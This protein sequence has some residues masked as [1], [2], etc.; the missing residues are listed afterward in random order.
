[1]GGV[2]VLVCKMEDSKL[3]VLLALGTVGAAG[4]WWWL[5]GGTAP[6]HAPPPDPD[7]FTTPV[8]K[9]A[10]LYLYPVKSCH[11]IE[12]ESTQCLTRG[13]QY[14]RQVQWLS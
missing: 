4:V 2:Q 7:S 3:K 11:R 9:V 6:Q 5:R 10:K 14:D 8:A 1:M 13:L 12:L